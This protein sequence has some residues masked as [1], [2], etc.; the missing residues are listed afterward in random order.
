M[1]VTDITV[2][3]G[4]SYGPDSVKVH[5]ERF[6][7][8]AE[9]VSVCERRTCK[10][11]K[12]KIHDYFG[13]AQF[14]KDLSWQGFKTVEEMKDRLRT[15]VQDKDLLQNVSKFIHTAR[16]PDMDKL[17]KVT[18]DICGGGV[19]V[20]RFLAGAPDCMVSFKKNRERSDIV[21]VGINPIVTCSVPLEKAKEVG[22][23]IAK[24]IR[25]MEIAGYR[26]QV[27]AVALHGDLCKSY[28]AG[29]IIPIKKADAALSL[30]RL[31]YPLC[32]MSFARGVFFGW[33][34][35]DPELTPTSGLSSWVGAKFNRETDLS[36]MYAKVLGEDSIY[37]D[38]SQLVKMFDMRKKKESR[39]KV[40]DYVIAK[41]I[42]S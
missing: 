19:D 4:F 22:A 8:C 7:S 38:F 15:G 5:I 18:R 37:L 29:M 27:D 20:P 12:Y 32:D 17:I 42:G 26:V 31:L 33:A 2:P 35:Q 40:S 24:A 16:V 13:N 21:K 3:S 1:K 30:P 25:S 39:K 36:D 9:V 28:A 6:S 11:M 14:S 10:N 34:V 41:F 23:I